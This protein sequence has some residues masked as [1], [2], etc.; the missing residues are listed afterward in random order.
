M[1]IHVGGGVYLRWQTYKNFSCCG[2]WRS[3]G[4]CVERKICLVKNVHI[5]VRIV[6]IM[7]GERKRYCRLRIGGR[8]F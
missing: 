5:V 7:G 3:G 2:N 6:V 8:C 4:F 1:Y